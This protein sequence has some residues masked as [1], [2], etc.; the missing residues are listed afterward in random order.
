MTLKKHSKPKK[1]LPRSSSKISG[2]SKP[3]SKNLFIQSQKAGLPAP[4]WELDFFRYMVD[5]IGDDVMVLD[6]NSRI[7][8][9]NASMVK[10]MGY[11]K[12]NILQR[13]I[14]DFMQKKISV[15]QW[16]K[17]Y[18]M[19]AKRKRKPV[20]YMVNR[21]VKSGKVRTID[22]TAVYM[23]YKSEEYILVVSSSGQSFVVSA[24]LSETIS[25]PTTK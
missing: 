21:V 18:F 16:K 12:K 7:V 11:A 6:K 20:S 17:I 22:V 19:E 15:A 24:R 4:K 5:Q 2:K 8:F 13:S 23:P 1:S 10:A 3:S 14:T 9:V 25:S